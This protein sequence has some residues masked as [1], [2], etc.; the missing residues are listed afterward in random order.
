MASA[1]SAHRFHSH[2]TFSSFLASDPELLVFRR[3]DLL[4][5]RALLAFQSELMTLEAQLM[6]LDK[7]DTEDASMETMLSARCFETLLPHQSEQ[8]AEEAER[9]GL[10]R[11]I[12][13][14][15]YRYSQ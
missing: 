14:L 8:N 12:Q 15:T 1:T 2:A 6:E 10:I 7:Q 11:R 9:L 13:E 4:N 5:A 3:F